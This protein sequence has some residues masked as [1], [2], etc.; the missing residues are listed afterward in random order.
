[1]KEILLKWGVKLWNVMKCFRIGHE[2]KALVSIILNFG[3]HGNI[4]YLDQVSDC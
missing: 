1:M 4:K 3:I 2:W